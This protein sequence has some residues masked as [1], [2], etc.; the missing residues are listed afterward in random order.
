MA[1]PIA[2]DDPR[3]EHDACGVGFVVD[4]KGRRRTTSS[5]GGCRCW[6]TCSIAAPAAARRTP[7]TA[8][9][10]WSRCPTLPAEGDSELGFALPPAG[11]TAAGLV[12]LPTDPQ[13]TRS[14]ASA[15]RARSSRT[16]GQARARLARGAHRRSPARRDARAPRAGHR[17]GVHRERRRRSVDDAERLAIALRAPL[18][19][20]R[21]RV[22]HACRSRCP[23]AAASA[24]YIVSLSANTLIYKGML[25]ADQIAPMF[26]DLADPDMES[27]LALVHS[28]LQHEH[29]SVVAAGPSLSLRRAQRRD[30]H[31]ARQHQLDARARRPARAPTLFGD[32]L[33]KILPIIRDGGSDTATFDNVPRVARHGRPLAAARDADDDSGAVAEHETM[34][35]ERQGVLRVPRVPDGAVGR[36]GVDRVHRRHGDRRRARSQRPAPSRYYVTKDDLVDHGVRGRRARHPARRHRAQGAAAARAR[37]SS[38]TRR[39]PHRDRRGDQARARGRAARTRRG[40]TRT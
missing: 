17:A 9:A 34:T 19:V 18:Y 27:A 2:L 12:F 31:A 11:S 26:P 29:V 23:S 22:E 33:R 20:I 32:E 15:C 39:G 8:R 35:P 36:P 5:R 25:T 13:P 37:C 28:A 40:S 24:F 38:W 3:D 30:Q 6:S 1:G 7:A 16:E 14:T 21:K 10:S 4:I